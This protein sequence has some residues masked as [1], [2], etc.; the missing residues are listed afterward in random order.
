MVD[1]IG[2]GNFYVSKLFDDLEKCS[3]P[4]QMKIKI[5]F[6]FQL[7]SQHNSLNNDFFC[8]VLTRWSSGSGVNYKEIHIYYHIRTL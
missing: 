2:K 1:T 3:L 4:F 6:F 7:F 8:S 5:E